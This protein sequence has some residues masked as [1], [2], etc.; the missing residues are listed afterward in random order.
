MRWLE[1]TVEADA[2]AVEAVSEILG[3]LGRGAA[4]R[5]PRLLRAPGAVWAVR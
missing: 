2:E 1:L 4:V 3:R 5:P